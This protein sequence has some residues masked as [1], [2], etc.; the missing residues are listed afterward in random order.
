MGPLSLSFHKSLNDYSRGTHLG[1][2]FHTL[3]SFLKYLTSKLGRKD[4]PFESRIPVEPLNNILNVHFPSNNF[5]NTLN[6][7]VSLES[8][9]LVIPRI[10]GPEAHVSFSLNICH[11]PSK[12][13]QHFKLTFSPRAIENLSQETI[14]LILI[15]CTNLC[16]S[17]RFK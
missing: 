15:T 17:L 14:C 1:V 5:M 3:F 8:S 12:N 10:L 9:I 16:L 2:A 6:E 13:T 7:N 11:S 4:V